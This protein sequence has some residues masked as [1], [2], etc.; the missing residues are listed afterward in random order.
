[1]LIYVEPASIEF[2]I[3]SFKAADGEITTSPA[4]ILLI[5]ASSSF[6]MEGLS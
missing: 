6:L 3:N 5:V 2:S 4:A 1:M